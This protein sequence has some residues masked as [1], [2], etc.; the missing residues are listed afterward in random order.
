M[1]KQNTIIGI[2]IILALIIDIVI[3]YRFQGNQKKVVDKK[4]ENELYSEKFDYTILKFQRF[5]YTLGQNMIV[6]V[7]KSTDGGK[8]FNIITQDGVVVSNKARFDFFDENVAFIISRE[9]IDRNNKFSG[10]KVSQDGGKTFVDAKFS[11]DNDR[12]DILHINDFPYYNDE[13]KLCLECTIYDIAP[14]GNGYADY[15]ITFVSD[16]NGLTWK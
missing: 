1:K 3:I 10:L 7:E 14:D 11:Y 5:D 16:D 12:V 13:K 4:D 6:G 2:I 9:L 15:L 8:T